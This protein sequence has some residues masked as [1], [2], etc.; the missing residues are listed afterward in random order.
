M[1][2]AATFGAQAVD[3]NG[4]VYMNPAP[5]ETIT[6]AGMMDMVTINYGKSVISVDD[7]KVATLTNN[8]TQEVISS[9]S[10]ELWQFALTMSQE[11][12]LL[13]NFPAITSNG[14][15]TLTVPAGTMTA[16]SES[17]PEL[18][19]TYVIKDSSLD[20][21]ELPELQLISVDPAAGSVLAAPGTEDGRTYTID[22]NLNNKIGYFDVSW[23]DV[24]NYDP[25]DE[26]S[27][28]IY[29]ASTTAEHEDDELVPYDTPLTF[30]KISVGGDSF[31]ENHK[32]QM[33]VTCFNSIAYPRRTIGE[34]RV[35]YLGS[36]KEYE[37]ATQQL[38]SISPNPQEYVIE[39]VS[40]AHFTLIFDGPVKIDT[41]RGGIPTGPATYDHFASVTPNESG[42]QWEIV[43][44]ESALNRDTEINCFVFATDDEGRAVLPCEDLKDYQNGQEDYACFFISYKNGLSA[45]P[46]VVN[47]VSGVVEKLDVFEISCPAD[48]VAIDYRYDNVYPKI[49]KD[50]EV[51]YQFTS[52]DLDI[53]W[54]VVDKIWFK[55][56]EAITEPGHYALVVPFGTLSVSYGSLDWPE[57][58][59]NKETTIGYTIEGDAPVS[60]VSYDLTATVTPAAGDV[61]SLQHFMI[62]FEDDM[63]LVEYDAYLY[64]GEGTQLAKADV[65]FDDDWDN[66]K[67]Y[68]VYLDNEITAP[69]TYVL[70]I[71]QG[72]WGDLTFADSMGQKGH[73]SA[74]IR[75]EYTIKDS[76]VEAILLEGKA[77]VY[78]VAG[79]CV[80]RNASAAQLSTLPRGIYIISGHKVVIK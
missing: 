60:D 80:L 18:T 47:P 45:K 70:V 19:F 7:T 75:V 39:D 21:E 16:D 73:G 5:G 30:N 56:P 49:V 65:A 68:H 4:Y 71:P 57:V 32:Y 27:E 42:T 15:Y 61:T 23:Y 53:D 17:N 67:D 44:P 62:S 43:L 64:D 78:N 31:Y 28:P 72:T 24:T 13:M 74:E 40:D 3:W 14:T 66:L 33:V 35:D 12:T 34:I 6:D 8:D 51:V 26:D 10:V 22:T 58:Y 25:T 63:E 54:D 20:Q 41:D 50:K 46:I 69:G 1:A 59:P 2:A 11:Y 77:N 55:L 52:Q 36:T 37:Y 76:A 29:I 38:I 48:A 9:T 79:V